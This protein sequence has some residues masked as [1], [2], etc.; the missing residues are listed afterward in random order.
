MTLSAKRLFSLYLHQLWQQLLPQVPSLP[1]RQ[2]QNQNTGDLPANNIPVAPGINQGELS[3]IPVDQ[4]LQDKVNMANQIADQFEE[5]KPKGIWA[6]VAE[7]FG[8]SRTID[9]QHQ[10][11][12]NLSSDNI[13]A[14]PAIDQ[15]VL[16]QIP[17]DQ[18]LKDKVDMSSQI[19]DQFADQMLVNQTATD[20]KLSKQIA[21]DRKLAEQIAADPKSSTPQHIKK[22]QRLS[23]NKRNQIAMNKRKE[24]MQRAFKSKGKRRQ[25]RSRRRR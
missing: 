20:P 7:F 6:K 9:E 22:T 16:S 5:N 12:A 17:V 21:A 13:P 10:N 23:Q 1:T 4:K 25:R 15:D 8:F 3:K 2:E 18:K 19:A 24:L 14:A 11:S